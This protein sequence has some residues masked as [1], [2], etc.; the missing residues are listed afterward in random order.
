MSVVNEVEVLSESACLS[1][2]RSVDVGRLAIAINNV[3]DIFPIN[4]VMDGETVVFRTA[5]GTK[6]AGA[7]LG[8]AV[9]VGVGGYDG[10]AGGA[11]GVGGEGGG[12][13]SGEM[14]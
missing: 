1:L 5:E 10:G 13:G 8:V 12:G 11:W 7:L 2:L 9:G 3:P 4:F 6:L 14:Y